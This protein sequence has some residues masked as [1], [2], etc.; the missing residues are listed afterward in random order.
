MI[1]AYNTGTRPV[2]RRVLQSR[3]AFDEAG[4]LLIEAGFLLHTSPVKRPFNIKAYTC[5]LLIHILRVHILLIRLLH[6]IYC[7]ILTEC[8]ETD[9][10]IYDSKR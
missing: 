7:N 10:N 9:C 3:G 2:N 5:T 8:D 6:N 1:K 4:L